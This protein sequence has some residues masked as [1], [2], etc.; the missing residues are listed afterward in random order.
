MLPD[1]VIKFSHFYSSTAP[2]PHMHDKMSTKQKIYKYA[3]WVALLSLV[4]IQF[5]PIDRK[6]PPVDE[7][8]DLLQMSNPDSNIASLMKAACYDCHSHEVTY[9]WY[10]KIAPLS[11]WID[12][13]IEHGVKK[14]NYSI[15]G[16][17]SDD[18][19]HHKLEESI[20]MMEQQ[21]MPLQSYTWMHSDA[22]LSAEDYQLLIT[23]FESLKS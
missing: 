5:I 15:W 19:R 17:Y 11:F 3:P 21:S 1:K 13:H 20:E 2:V 14:L 10:S 12:G 9:P 22:R 23:Y 7:S 4:I 8:K 6:Q 16:D 18:R